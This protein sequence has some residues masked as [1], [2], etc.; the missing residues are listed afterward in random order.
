MEKQSKVKIGDVVKLKSGGPQMTVNDF[1]DAGGHY[2]EG[3]GIQCAWFDG[4]LEP[5]RQIFHI[6][7]LDVVNDK[8]SA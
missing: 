4:K 3:E 2:E 1:N 5:Q 7:A 6:D 8:K